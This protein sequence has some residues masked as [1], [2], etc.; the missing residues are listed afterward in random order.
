[1][2]KIKPGISSNITR[3]VEV[4]DTT[5]PKM[6]LKYY[7]TLSNSDL[8]I[9]CIPNLEN[10]NYNNENDRTNFVLKDNKNY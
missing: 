5:P 9:N 6:F 8:L 3:N 1:M 4:K 7:I 2:E 10:I